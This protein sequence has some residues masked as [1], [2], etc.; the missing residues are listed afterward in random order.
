MR[1]RGFISVKSPSRLIFQPFGIG[2]STE[3]TRLRGNRSYVFN[4]K[5][6]KGLARSPLS[7]HFDPHRIE[8]NKP[9]LEQCSRH[10]FQRRIHPTVQFDLVVECSEDVGNCALFGRGETR[11]RNLRELVGRYIGKARTSRTSQEFGKCKLDYRPDKRLKTGI[12][13]MSNR[14]NSTTYGVLSIGPVHATCGRTADA[15]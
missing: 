2:P 5:V 1:S 8:I 4:G 11:T 13:T 7:P 15:E 6:G 14:R 12:L 9:R 10:C 3:S